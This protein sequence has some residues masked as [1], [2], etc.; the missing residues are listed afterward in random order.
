MK[1]ECFIP[2][3]LPRK[4]KKRLYGKR[5]S[6]KSLPIAMMENKKLTPKMKKAFGVFYEFDFKGFIQ[7]V[8]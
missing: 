5:K 1:K 4:K 2:Q 6:R 3:N 7:D 8:P